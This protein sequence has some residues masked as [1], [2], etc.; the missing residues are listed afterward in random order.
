MYSGCL[1]CRK[2]IQHVVLSSTECA[3]VGTVS[4]KDRNP[5]STSSSVLRATPLVS[6]RI[7]F[8]LFASYLIANCNVS[9]MA[10][11]TT[12]LVTISS[13][14]LTASKMLWTFLAFLTVCF[15]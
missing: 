4:N 9:C 15:F 3:D 10:A 5:L 11:D 2:R 12:L 14:S 6:Y 8:F 7:A 1:C 13:M